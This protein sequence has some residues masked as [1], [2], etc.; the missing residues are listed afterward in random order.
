MRYCC[1]FIALLG[2]ICLS[3]IFLALAF[4]AFTNWN[5]MV[6]T[7][8]KMGA[9]NAQWFLVA[10]TAL[11]LLGGLSLLIGYKTR[12]GALLLIVFLVPVTLMMHNFWVAQPDVERDLQFIMFFKNV[13][14]LGG[15]LYVLAYGCGGCSLD[16]CCGKSC[17]D[18]TLKSS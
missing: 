9:P 11:M 18:D 13:A 17:K 15:L 6:Q 8:E 16:G 5:V 4:H 2:R 1:S 7:V 14:I 3:L 10:G 12:I